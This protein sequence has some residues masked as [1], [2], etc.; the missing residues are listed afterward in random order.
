MQIQDFRLPNPSFDFVWVLL[1]LYMTIIFYGDKYYPH[2]FFL[3]YFLP[4]HKISFIPTSL[5]FFSSF[6]NFIFMS[7]VK[8]SYSGMFFFGGGVYFYWWGRGV[9]EIKWF[10]CVLGE[11]IIEWMFSP[12]TWCS[13]LVCI[14]KKY[15]SN[16]LYV[17]IKYDY[18]RLCI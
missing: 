6:N 10:L 9:E 16:N 12:R 11:T 8:S 13:D 3:G 1:L 7:K 18:G 2:I 14:L 17:L 15:L 4:S 5:F